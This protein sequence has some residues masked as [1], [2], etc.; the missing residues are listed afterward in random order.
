MKNYLL[1]I[2]LLLSFAGCT[3]SQ[4]KNKTATVTTKEQH[5]ENRLPEWFYTPNMNIY[6]YGGVGI[7]KKSA[8]GPSRQRQLAIGRA[9]DEIASQM[10]TK[11]SSVQEFVT[12]KDNTDHSGYSIH[13]TD[14]Q[15]VNAILM[16][17]WV[18]RKKEELYAWLVVEK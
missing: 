16:E 12:T 4:N 10:N 9:I 11:V 2:L 1:L 3:T 17:I 6:K 7:A 8:H 5:D 15:V 13:T 14:G 18:N